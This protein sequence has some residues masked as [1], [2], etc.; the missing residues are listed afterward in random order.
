MIERASQTWIIP[1][2]ASM[3]HNCPDC[4]QCCY[5]GKD[6]DD[7]L[8]DNDED[9]EACTHCLYSDDDEPLDG[10]PEDER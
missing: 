4:G 10:D 1:R 9:V 7:C 2:T 8:L 3:A 5:C 6:I